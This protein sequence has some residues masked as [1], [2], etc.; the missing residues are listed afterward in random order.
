M[1][2]QAYYSQEK[3]SCKFRSIF[4]STVKFLRDP[5]TEPGPEILVIDFFYLK[6]INFSPKSLVK[7]H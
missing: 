1:S 7:S 3:F 5:T 4:D 6:T 2:T